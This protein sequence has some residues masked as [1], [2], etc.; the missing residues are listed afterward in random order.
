MLPV[1]FEGIDEFVKVTGFHRKHAIRVA[2]KIP[3]LLAR[4]VSSVP[5]IPQLPETAFL[6]TGPSLACGHIPLILA[7][8]QLPIYDIAFYVHRLFV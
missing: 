3:L 1:R 4:L 6:E 5:G 2:G 8:R 7:I